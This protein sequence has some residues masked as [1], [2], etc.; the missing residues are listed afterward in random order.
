MP[1]CVRQC[2]DRMTV[3]S[4]SSCAFGA[5]VGAGCVG[6]ARPTLLGPSMDARARLLG[7]C[8]IDSFFKSREVEQALFELNPRPLEI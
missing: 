3:L 5:H 2:T 8:R 6:D 1:A 7:S 4:Y